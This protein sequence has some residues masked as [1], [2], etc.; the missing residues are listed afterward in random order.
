MHYNI[1]LNI[2]IHNYNQRFNQIVASNI[3][4]NNAP[5]HS[6]TIFVLQKKIY[7]IF[8]IKLINNY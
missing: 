1:E 4:V 5:L 7:Y 3:N 6:V 2:I 8:I